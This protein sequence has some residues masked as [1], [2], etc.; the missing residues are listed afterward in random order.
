[1]A[2]LKDWTI[3]SNNRSLTKVI[4][5]NKTYSYDLF[6]VTTSDCLVYGHRSGNNINLK[7]GDPGKSDNIR[8]QRKSGSTDPIK[9]EE[10][11]AIHVRKGN[12][13]V[14]ERGRWGINLGW[15]DTPKFEWKILGGK[16][17]DIVPAGKVVGLYSLVEKDSL[18]YE[19][20]DWGINLKWFKDSG[21]FNDLSGLLR[22][23][24]AVESIVDHIPK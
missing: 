1:M 23:G 9:F 15:S 21:K 13:L 22:A 18:M 12:F 7:W 10:P 24:K 8:F 5:D 17:G 20:R 3:L 4:P 6:N 11:L 16:A 14:Y 2:E 19:S